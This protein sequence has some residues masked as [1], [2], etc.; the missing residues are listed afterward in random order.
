MIFIYFIDFIDSE[1]ARRR[2]GLERCTCTYFTSQNKKIGESQDEG[3]FVSEQI[4]VCLRERPR[5]VRM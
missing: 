1:R 4:A 2:A 5:E 3:P